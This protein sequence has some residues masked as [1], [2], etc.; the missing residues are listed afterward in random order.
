MLKPILKPIKEARADAGFFFCAC[1]RKR[2]KRLFAS[3]FA[4]G[5][6][7]IGKIGICLLT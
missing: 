7:K 5:E 6:E 3:A 1:R 2:G 4:Y